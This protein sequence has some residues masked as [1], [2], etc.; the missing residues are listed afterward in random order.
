MTIN[1]PEAEFWNYFWTRL[2]QLSDDDDNGVCVWA[3]SF[4]TNVQWTA[5]ICMSI[6]M[7]IQP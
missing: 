4:G 5:V 1:K 3:T 2:D 7:F 6:F